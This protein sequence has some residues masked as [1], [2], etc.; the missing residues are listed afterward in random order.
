VE[1]ESSLQCQRD[2]ATG[3]CS[4]RNMC[5]PYPPNYYKITFNFLPHLWLGNNTMSKRNV[6]NQRPELIIIYFNWEIF[7]VC[8]YVVLENG[9]GQM[10]RC[11]RLNRAEK[12]LKFHST[13]D[14]TTRSQVR[15]V[16]KIK[17]WNM[18]DVMP[19]RLVRCEWRRLIWHA[20]ISIWKQFSLPT[21]L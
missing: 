17:M 20:F 19:S 3:A 2:P 9:R 5:R 7:C 8:M 4:K 6:S 10:R 12:R 13:Q 15:K 11:L 21:L 16:R 14:T 18:W 1:S